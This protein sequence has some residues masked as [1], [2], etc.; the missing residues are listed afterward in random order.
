[1]INWVA[2]FCTLQSVLLLAG[3]VYKLLGARDTAGDLL[4]LLGVLLL[5]ALVFLALGITMYGVRTTDEL[6]RRL[7]FK[8]A[9][10]A[11]E[12]IV[13]K[14][15]PPHNQVKLKT[16]L[17]ISY[18][19]VDLHWLERLCKHLAPLAETK[20]YI[21]LTDRGLRPGDDWSAEILAMMYRAKVSISLVSP[22]YLD[23]PY[24]KAIEIPVML[25]LKRK[26]ELRPT[27]VHLR[28][29]EIIPHEFRGLQAAHDVKTPVSELN[30]T[31]QEAELI[32]IANRTLL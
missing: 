15:L 7:T 17:F 16:A 25:E 31:E 3:V 22:E 12:H 5:F 30:E 14:G 19:R 18:A 28:K 21:I 1:M 13:N 11:I 29:C 27:W 26:R 6:F 10:A 8:R 2:L 23:S 4:P 20:D 9:D 32:G 24:V